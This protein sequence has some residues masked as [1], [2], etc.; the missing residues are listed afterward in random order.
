[1]RTIS[2]LISILFA[3][4][5]FLAFCMAP[6]PL[7]AQ[8]GARTGPVFGYE[9]GVPLELDRQPGIINR[10]R[11]DGR[12]WSHSHTISGGAHLL[13]PGVIIPN[14]DASTRLL[15]AASDGQ[16]MSFPYEAVV[17]GAPG[18]DSI[19]VWEEFRVR[20]IS[21]LMQLDLRLRYRLASA[22][23]VE[24]GVWGRLRFK[25]TLTQTE[26]I[27]SPGNVAFP[28]AGTT[29]LV[30]Q[31]E[32]ISSDPFRYGL[33]LGSS[34][35]I[36]LG[37]VLSVRPELY[38]RADLVALGEGVGVR[39]FSVGG[40][41]SLLF[42]LRGDDPAVPPDMARAPQS[43]SDTVLSLR[44]PLLDASVDLYVAADG[45][46]S[47]VAAVR[48]RSRSRRHY[49]PL[50]PVLFFDEG[51]ERLPERYTMLSAAEAR[52]FSRAW[53]A[54][55]DAL[56]LY[57]QTL[58]VIGWRLRSEMGA[59]VVLYGSAAR[60]EEPALAR[61]RAEGVAAYLRDVW[62]IDSARVEV[63]KGRGPLDLGAGGGAAVQIVSRSDRMMAPVVA[64][65]VERERY[66]PRIGMIRSVQSEAGVKGWTL[67]VR[68]GESVLARSSNAARESFDGIDGA[69]VLG[70]RGDSSL[71]IVAE[72]TV[73]D[74]AGGS[75]VVCDTL[76]VLEGNEPGT[77]A[78][79]T[80]TYTFIGLD[81]DIP[82]LE[83][84]NNTLI[85]SL[86]ATI[87]DSARVT[88][89][90]RGGTPQG[91]GTPARRVWGGGM[92]AQKLL[93][94][95]RQEGKRPAE[96]RLLPGSL[97]AGAAGYPEFPLLKTGAA[98]VVEQPARSNNAERP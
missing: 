17:A 9:F 87:A 56:E 10:Y 19:K 93:E 24:A 92:V 21:H 72:L 82:L 2:P 76:P 90:D 54:R 62:G 50:L 86:A 40:G 36:P 16:F 8:E 73:E 26:H 6:E 38:G 75:V 14:L 28:G 25:S 12:G 30:A 43:S 65:W 96:V 7:H 45:A 55:L 81:R 53:F 5:L 13:L 47:D 69:F 95:L 23:G 71:P 51:S 44:R 46:R 88:V 61:R 35:D 22:W 52:N 66:L 27:L 80:F 57:Y 79:E 85:A 37:D 84:G 15:Y 41:F 31:G 34:V 11:S 1:M 98:I 42:D 32:S 60:G 3:A 63:A 58:N 89:L 77:D 91:E 4:G 94:E 39:A 74:L 59:G 97:P 78:G 83:R 68:R 33:T 29:R 70:A 20:A 18:E 49:M 67:T 48:S 64:E